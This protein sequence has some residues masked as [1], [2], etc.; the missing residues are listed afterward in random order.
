VKALAASEETVE[1]SQDEACAARICAH[2]QAPEPV[3]HQPPKTYGGG[4]SKVARRAGDLR[5]PE[6]MGMALDEHLVVE[7][8][9]IPIVF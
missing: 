9:T 1:K 2:P 3:L 6:A 7:N 8:E 5:D 4:L